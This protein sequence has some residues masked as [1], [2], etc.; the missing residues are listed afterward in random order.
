MFL[1]CASQIFL[2]RRGRFLPCRRL[3]SPLAVLS[4]VRCLL[5]R[6]FVFLLYSP[7]LARVVVRSYMEWLMS[8]AELW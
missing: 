5:A 4:L 7:L 8:F 2:R 1:D 3:G 6:P